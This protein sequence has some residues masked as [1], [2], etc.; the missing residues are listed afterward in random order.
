[1]PEPVNLAVASALLQFAIHLH[2]TAGDLGGSTIVLDDSLC[3]QPAKVSREPGPFAVKANF[4]AGVSSKKVIDALGFPFANPKLELAVAVM[5]AAKEA[6]V[7]SRA[8]AQR[9]IDEFVADMA[10]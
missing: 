3:V 7:A 9:L 5:V 1:M 10:A 4:P 6:M 8:E 2:R